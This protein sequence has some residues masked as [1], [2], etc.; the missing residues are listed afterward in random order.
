[1]TLIAANGADSSRPAELTESLEKL[2]ECDPGAVAFPRISEL[3]Y[4]MTCSDTLATPDACRPMA[5]AAPNARSITRPR[6]NGPRS[7]MRTTT[8]RPVRTFITLTLVP[9]GSERWAAVNPCGL[10]RSPLAVFE[11]DL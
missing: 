10:K 11:P 9:N 2:E 1:M 5:R 4:R 8:D 3:D 7:L 6:T